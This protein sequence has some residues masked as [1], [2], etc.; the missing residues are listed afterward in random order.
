MTV[1]FLGIKETKK[2]GCGVCGR[3]KVSNYTL[4]RY[5]KMTLPSGRVVS[6]AIGKP[7]NVSDEEGKFLL[8][9]TYD[10]GGEKAYMFKKVE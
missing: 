7:E 8:S 1:E 5:R 6:F 3:R 4:S 10:L 2:N 9:L